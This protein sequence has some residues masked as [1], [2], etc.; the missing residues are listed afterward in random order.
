MKITCVDQE[1]RKILETNYYKIPR[2]QRPYSWDKDNIQDF[3]ADMESHKPN[4]FFI[5]SMVVYIKGNYRHI[6]D[7]QQRLTTITIL[8][9]A[10]RDKFL[11]I[12]LESQAKGL[13]KLI[14]RT[15]LDNDEEFVIQTGSSYPFFQQHIQSFDK[16]TKNNPPGDEEILLKDAYDQ[17]KQL[18]D[19]SVDHLTNQAKKKKKIES[20]R[21]KLLSLKAIYVEVDN[22]DDAYIIFETLNTRGKDLTSADL[23]KNHLAKQLRQ[24]NTKNDIIGI[25]WKRIRD[26][27]DSIEIL[28]IKID[29][30]VYH[31][32]LATQEFTTEKEIYKRAKIAIP[33]KATAKVFIDSLKDASETYKYIFMP[34]TKTWKMEENKIKRSLEAL[35]TFR[36]RQPV[37]MILALMQAYKSKHLAKK[38][39][40]R[41][42]LAI[43]LFHYAFTALT[44]QRSS[45]GISHMYALHARELTHANSNN[46]RTTAINNLITKLKARLPKEADFISG[47]N[48]LKYSD[49]YPKDKRVIQYTLRA[50]YEAE[51]PSV[52]IDPQQMT[53]EHIE[54]QSSTAMNPEKIAEIGNLWLVSAIVNNKLGDK[55]PSQKIPL[56]K[57]SKLQSDPI[58]DSA[59]SWTEEKITARTQHFSNK[60]WELVAKI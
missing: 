23:L 41:A 4:E 29:N 15:N 12:G 26:N 25:E 10:L 60:V 45:G 8:L 13:Q 14:E 19:S 53:I 54:P 39:T 52:A 17:L 31:F 38:E 11:S 6:V 9:A 20:I 56:Y 48:K 58:L 42:L 5:G 37:P 35:L 46:Q 7:G 16:S 30:F 50:L 33:D 51:A 49:E 27:I 18:I 34:N 3:W 2:F 36:V 24:P 32:W 22:E 1:I 28:D 43:E 44:S 40:E 47:F 57:K 21:D 59:T 55:S